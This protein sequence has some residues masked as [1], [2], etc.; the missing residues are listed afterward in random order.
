MSEPM[1]SIF[2]TDDEIDI[3]MDALHELKMAAKFNEEY[4]SAAEIQALYKRFVEL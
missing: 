4:A 1:C 3:I 2:L